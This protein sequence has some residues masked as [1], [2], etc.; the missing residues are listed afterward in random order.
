MMIKLVLVGVVAAG[1]GAPISAF[2]GHARLHS[3]PIVSP[4]RSGGIS[5]MAS[6]GKWGVRGDR[7]QFVVAITRPVENRNFLSQLAH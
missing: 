3:C 2:A 4:Q 7:A 5:E 1:L 6:C